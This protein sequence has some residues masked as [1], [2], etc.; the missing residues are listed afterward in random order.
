MISC[1][2]ENFFF[3]RTELQTALSNSTHESCTL[4][5]TVRSDTR[6]SRARK[7]R[8][9]HFVSRTRPLSLFLSPFRDSPLYLG[10][11]FL[12]V[13]VTRG[14][15]RYRASSGLRRLE[16]SVPTVTRSPKNEDHDRARPS[17]SPSLV[18]SE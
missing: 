3:S 2:E 5:L 11:V 6:Y 17:K 15:L 1:N 18:A 16:F 7:I 8:T 10:R 12:Y 14:L 4:L 13:D 9:P